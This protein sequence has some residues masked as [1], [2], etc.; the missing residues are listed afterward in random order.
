MTRANTQALAEKTDIQSP[1]EQNHY[2]FPATFAQQRLWFL[3]QMQPG[4]T[5]YSIPWSI[6]IS[7]QLDCQ[8]L[9]R[10]INEIVRRH[11]ILRTT[12][13]LVEGEPSQVIAKHLRIPLP[14]IDLSLCSDRESEA[15]KLIREEA[16]MPMD[17]QNGPLV[18]GSILRTGSS[19]HILLLTFHHI[20]FDGWS[21]HIFVSELAALYDAFRRDRPSPLPE[22]KLQY[23][24]YAVWQR[25]QLQGENLDKQ[26]AYWKQQLAG[27][28]GNVE[29]RTDYVRPAV[30]T[31]NGASVPVAFPKDVAERLNELSR[32]HG[33]TLFM[34]LLAVFDVL[35]AR[36]SGQQDIVVG[37]P[38]ANRNR[39]EI[40]KLIGFFA[41]TLALRTDLSGNPRFIDVLERV[42]ETALGAYAHQDV[43]FEKLVEELQ[44]ERSLS[45]NPLFQVLFAL[46]N[47]PQ[48]K[49]ELA[50]LELK[51]LD[52]RIE[53]AKFD[54][55]VFLSDTSEGLR[56]RLEYNTDLYAP[57]TIQR[58]IGH[59]GVL[60]KSVAEDPNQRIEEI[61]L[62]TEPERHQLLV[63]W[64]RT[65]REYPDKCIHELFEMQAERTPEAIAVVSED[66]QLSYAELNAQA[67]RLANHLRSLGVGPDVTVGL[68]VERSLDMMVGLLGILK[69]GGAYVP[70]D[71]EYPLQRLGFLIK[72]SGVKTILTHRGFHNRLPLQ[73]GEI[74][75]LD[76]ANTW[77]GTAA[78]V[79][80]L[81]DNLAYVMFTSGST[82]TPKGVETPHRAIVRL[83]FGVDYAK[84][85]NQEVFLQLAPL[86]FDASTL[87]IWGALLHGARLVVCEPG[88][89]TP[90]TLGT[91]LSR[92]RVTTMWLTAAMFNFI[93]DEAPEILRPVRQLL[94][95][96]EALSVR[97]IR[98]AQELLP[99]TQLINGYGPTET[100]TFAACYPIPA[101]F[102]ERASSIPLGRPIGNTTVYVLDRN[103]QLV[104]IG[105]PGELFIGGDGLARGYVQQPDQTAAKFVSNPFCADANQRVDKQRLYATGDL[106]R[107]LTDGRLEFIG[108]SD[109]QVK[110]RGFRIEPGEIAAAIGK[111][112]TVQECLVVVW[113]HGG[114]EKRLVG[115]V[116]PIPGQ[117]I[118]PAELRAWLK[119]RLPEYMV[120]AVIIGLTEFP[121]TANGKVNRKA[122]PQPVFQGETAREHAS[123]DP[124]E[125]RL[126]AIWGKVLGVALVSKDDDFFN[127]GGHSLSAVRLVTEIEK[128][129]GARLPL[130][131]LF[132][133]ST[134]GQMAHLIRQAALDKPLSTLIPIHPEGSRP[135]L[136]CVS[137]PN[138]NVLGYMF[139]SRKLGAE[140]PMYGL[141][142][143]LGNPNLQPFTQLE[144]E[145]KAAEYIE[146]MKQVRPHGPYFLTGHCEGAHIA[147]EMVRQLERAGESVPIL[148][149]LD[150][151][152]QENTRNRF[153]FY[154]FLHYRRTLQ[155]LSSGTASQMRDIRRKLGLHP[156]TENGTSAESPVSAPPEPNYFAL[157][158]ERYWPGKDYVPPKCNAPIIV[159]RAARQ[160]FWR[161]RDRKM[162]WQAR[163]RSNVRVVEVKGEHN[164]ILREPA[165]S[166]VAE[167]LQGAISE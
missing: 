140:Q 45:H 11:E 157:M 142:S 130:S 27:V 126:C 158:K 66:R 25:K 161:I 134:L 7:G 47:A 114:G 90:H 36:Y 6:R 49:F 155:F 122:L 63:E 144:Y 109:D 2:V 16:R 33:A 95:G 12:F 112:P 106:V 46:R 105:V 48:Q 68:C 26:V 61:Q 121:R 22:V 59:F 94:V 73:C 89:P 128:V 80:A 4:N 162:G 110:I 98:R 143:Q 81:L 148:A 43:P 153:L 151:W 74:V 156:R 120:P 14:V 119:Q 92:H 1:K 115:Y 57:E 146:A 160:Q 96:G 52:T 104:P 86:A 97:H 29:L 78:P 165:I 87:E 129:F 91:L 118:R 152:P 9:Q 72:S 8:A 102:D 135:P 35:L 82:G 65:E 150:A 145:Q 19:D 79:R 84:F 76:R 55:S 167:V 141:Q 62:L 54:L 70:L 56:G 124:T 67:N 38:I 117:S 20:V 93:I 131:S 111:H 3:D 99:D 39:V 154:L 139:L 71:P 77:T 103:R 31:C 5:S 132:Q 64:N 69:A 23:A 125:L 127:L 147:F 100:T 58:L 30:Q 163:T 44:P 40:E 138:V 21:R 75:F 113:Q 123:L 34:T 108:R 101:P 42:K 41:N 88:A 85:S 51:V 32:Q 107:Y 159:F 164:T 24:D 18:R 60:L 15:E 166:K 28:S 116:V 50:D 149:V 136:F 133:A 83:L 13:S 10:T 37:T 17:L 53:T 137:R